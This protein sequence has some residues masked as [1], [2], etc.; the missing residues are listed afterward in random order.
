MPFSVL[1]RM[2]EK[3]WNTHINLI[4]ETSGGV[5][6]HT[7]F[8]KSSAVDMN[9]S[10]FVKKMEIYNNVYRTPSSLSKAVSVGKI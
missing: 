2:H 9:R 10:Y 5:R 3:T 8:R 4:T 1:K 7:P 6:K